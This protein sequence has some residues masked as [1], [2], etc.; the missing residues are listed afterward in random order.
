M[1]LSP[2]L[3][4]FRFFDSFLLRLASGKPLPFKQASPALLP[5]E[6]DSFYIFLAGLFSRIVWSFRFDGGFGLVS[7]VSRVVIRLITC[8]M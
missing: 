8:L 6:D 2:V 5:G 4:R 1:K 3:Y 7:M